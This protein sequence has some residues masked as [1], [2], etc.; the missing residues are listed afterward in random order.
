MKESEGCRS[1]F[2]YM[3]EWVGENVHQEQKKW[4]KYSVSV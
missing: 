1:G 2:L 4:L 3:G